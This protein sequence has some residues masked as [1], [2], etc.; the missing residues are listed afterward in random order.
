MRGSKPEGYLIATLGDEPRVVLNTLEGTNCFGGVWI[1]L[2]ATRA[3]GIDQHRRRVPL[4]ASSG[5]DGSNG[6]YRRNVV[7]G[8]ACIGIYVLGDETRSS[9]P[10]RCNENS[11]QG[12]AAS[13]TVLNN[14]ANENSG[15]GISVGIDKTPSAT[16]VLNNTANDNGGDGIFASPGVID[17]G[18][19]TATGNGLENCV[20]VSCP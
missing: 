2:Y 3:V 11:G 10:T 18:G 1:Y 6:R 12:I 17:G 5:Q 20:N 8:T 7:T 15:T 4:R 19:N 13:G 9:G 14:T 16:T